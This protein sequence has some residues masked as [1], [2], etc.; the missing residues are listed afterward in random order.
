MQ[1]I[2]RLEWGAFSRATGADSRLHLAQN[3][4][5]RLES[6]RVQDMPGVTREAYRRGD[7][8]AWRGTSSRDGKTVALK[9]MTDGYFALSLTCILVP[10]GAG[11]RVSGLNRI[12]SSPK[13]QALGR[14]ICPKTIL[15]GTMISQIVSRR[16]EHGA[17][18]TFH[19]P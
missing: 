7:L 6:G 13:L 16:A 17:S 14:I 9:P 5:L 15:F 8:L 1:T 12:R 11:S 2:R 4:E 18:F 3:L 19:A 10:H